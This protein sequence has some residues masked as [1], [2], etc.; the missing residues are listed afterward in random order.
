DDCC[1][2]MVISGGGKVNGSELVKG[3]DSIIQHQIPVTGGLAGDGLT[4][5]RPVAGLNTTPTEGQIIAIGFYGKSLSTSFFST[6]G[7][8]TFGPEIPVTRASGNRLYGINGQSALAL[9][10]KYLGPYADN[11]PGS[12][13]LFPLAVKWSEDTPPI[14]RT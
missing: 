6:G 12:A 11:L 14:V 5:E 3:I 2:I 1:H 10:K 9:Y 7:W 4:F 8:E 13:L